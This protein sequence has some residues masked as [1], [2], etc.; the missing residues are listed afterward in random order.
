ME[1]SKEKPN[2]ATW[3]IYAFERAFAIHINFLCVCPACKL[4]STSKRLAIHSYEWVRCNMRPSFELDSFNFYV[5]YHFVCVCCVA[6]FQTLQFPFRLCSQMAWTNDRP[7]PSGNVVC[8]MQRVCCLFY[9]CTFVCVYFYC[10]ITCSK[11]IITLSSGRNAFRIFVVE[12]RRKKQKP[13]TI[14][15]N[16]KT[17]RYVKNWMMKK[18]HEDERELLYIIYLHVCMVECS[19][20]KLCGL[21]NM[22]QFNEMKIGAQHKNSISI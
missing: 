2:V 21:R 4:Q 8:S 19:R 20:R 15:S 17:E 6:S 9:V 22:D 11:I 16:K 7:T 12:W 13:K 10:L 5:I 14:S 3:H 18:Q 1:V